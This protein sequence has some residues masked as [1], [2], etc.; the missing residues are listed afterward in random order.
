MKRA[1]LPVLDKI[2]PLKYINERQQ[3]ETTDRINQDM[4][5]NILLQI[6]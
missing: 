4:M 5:G 3:D 1:H 6:C 2:K